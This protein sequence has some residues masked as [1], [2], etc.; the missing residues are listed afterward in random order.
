MSNQLLQP[1]IEDQQ[2]WVEI[3]D[4]VSPDL[5]V[6][7]F[8]ERVRLVDDYRNPLVTWDE[9]RTSALSSF[10]A[11]LDALGNVDSDRTIEIAAHVGITRAR[12][13]IPMASLMTAIRVD[14]QVLWNAIIEVAEDSDSQLLIRHANLVWMTV[15]NYVRQTQNTYIA[16]EKR[17]AD[18]AG[19][20]RRKLLAELLRHEE[21]SQHR[22]DVIAES[23]GISSDSTFFVVAADKDEQAI[24]A[25]RTELNRLERASLTPFAQYR[26][27]SLVM[28]LEVPAAPTT[29]QQ[30]ALDSLRQFPFGLIDHAETLAGLRHAV[31]LAIQLAGLA[32]TN[33]VT[34]ELGWTRLI[35]DRVHDLNLGT[36]LDVH[37]YLADCGEAERKN[38]IAAVRA[39]LR[40]GSVSEAAEMTFCHRNTLTNRLH[41]FQ[42]LTGVDVTVPQE[43]AL[44]VVLW[45]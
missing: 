3:L 11:L 34:P 30:L 19:S 5:L 27:T 37:P 39:F 40:T 31:P 1:Q 23:L 29:A 38:L 16:E 9:I 10:L 18:E 36:F 33:A 17:M 15:D 42:E 2:R 4:A 20:V 6:E 14:F 7:R 25:L 44:L 26:D 24:T 12:A 45:S 43:A 22:L 28:F 21:I 41:R 35:H 32:T 8:I 13:S